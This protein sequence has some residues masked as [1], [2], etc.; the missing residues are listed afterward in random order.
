VK[1]VVQLQLEKLNG[2]QLVDINKR[3]KEAG[4]TDSIEVMTAEELELYKGNINENIATAEELAKNSSDFILSSQEDLIAYNKKTLIKID[5]RLS[6]IRSELANNS[7]NFSP[8]QVELEEDQGGQFIV[9]GV[10]ELADF[11]GWDKRRVSDFYKRDR[12]EAPA[13]RT[14]GIRQRPLW[15][16]AQVKRIKAQFDK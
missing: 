9:Y 11:L 1:E 16:P 15:T 10:Q 8:T 12:I 4:I 7:D 14:A 6:S 5:D 3:A 2:N 13:G